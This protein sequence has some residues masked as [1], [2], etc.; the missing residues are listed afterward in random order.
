MK[1]ITTRFGEVEYDPEKT[2]EFPSGLIGFEDL[3][4]FIVMPNRKEGP[5]F[6]IQS[7]DDQDIAFVLADPTHFFRDYRV[8]PDAGERARLG[9]TEKDDCFVLAVVTVSQNQKVTLNLA[10]PILFA[11]TT[12]RALQVIVENSPYKVQTPLPH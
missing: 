7:I 1:T 9:I 10:A 3:R 2:L 5:L 4:R 11:P 12:N 6:W 8:G